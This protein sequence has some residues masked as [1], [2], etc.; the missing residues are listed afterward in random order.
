MAAVL[1]DRAR[2]DRRLGV[3]REQRASDG[4]DQPGGTQG[5]DDLREGLVVLGA[6][7]LAVVDRLLALDHAP[8][9]IAD[10]AVVRVRLVDEALLTLAVG[11]S[12][13]Q[14]ALGRV[15]V[16][17]RAARL[18]VVGLEAA[19]HPVVHHVADVRLVDA[20]AE[21]VGRDNDRRL[22]GGETAVRRRAL[23]AA[24]ARVVRG[25][26]DAHASQLLREFLGRLPR[27][28]VDDPR[29]PVPL[30]DVA[31]EPRLPVAVRFTR[32]EA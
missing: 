1:G 15:A 31:A 7:D 14:G 12:V 17:A 9:R 6:R 16:A 27:T 13:E 23:L 18:L 32:T 10:R 20:H 5:G 25:R 24:H 4:R 3:R 2:V 26:A 19:G 28:G 29:L 11:G 21:G 8:P 30:N 22:A